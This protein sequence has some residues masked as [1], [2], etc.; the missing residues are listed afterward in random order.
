[1][2]E[3]RGEVE[4]LLGYAPEEVTERTDFFG[5]EVIHPE[6]RERVWEEIQAAIDADEVFEESYRIRTK[7]GAVKDV[8]ERGQGVYDFDGSLTGLEGFITDVTDRA[9][10]GSDG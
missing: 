8:W 7:A 9:G 6:D 5:S 4:E 2:Q 3:V 10:N 1:M